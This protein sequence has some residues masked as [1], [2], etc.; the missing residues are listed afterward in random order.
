MSFEDL[1]NQVVSLHQKLITLQ[2][3]DLEAILEAS[4]YLENN[5]LKCTFQKM[6][7][8]GSY[9]YSITYYD[10]IEGE[11]GEGH[12][13]VSIKDGKLEADF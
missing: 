6:T 12:V 4:G 8:S 2:P 9:W 11:E 10:D 1:N 3:K 7:V 5:I 13:Y